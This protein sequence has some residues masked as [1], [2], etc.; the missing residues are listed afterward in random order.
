[1]TLA[2]T[3]DADKHRALDTAL[4]GLYVKQDDGNYRLDADIPDTDG[5]KAKADELLG[6]TK[7][8]RQKRKE[9]EQELADIFNSNVI[10]AMLLLPLRRQRGLLR[11]LG[12]ELRR[13]QGAPGGIPDGNEEGISDASG[14]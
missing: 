10:A 14:P 4:Q 11:Q 7:Q 12:G 3:L 6:E 13:R 5:L 2:L 8:E 1:M 9:L